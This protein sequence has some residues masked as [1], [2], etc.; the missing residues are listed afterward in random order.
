MRDIKFRVWSTISA[1]GVGK[2]IDWDKLKTG[3]LSDLETIQNQ[4]I[5]MQ[6]T[7]LLDKQGKEIYEGDIVDDEKGNM[8][9]IEWDDDWG[10]NSNISLS[11]GQSLRTFKIKGNIYENKELIK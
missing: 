8:F 10:W 9:A 6:F 11:N 2:M 3:S 7:G 5:V 1:G 4:W